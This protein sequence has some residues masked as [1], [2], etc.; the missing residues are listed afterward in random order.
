M[1]SFEVVELNV[2]VYSFA[3]LIHAPDIHFEIV[4]TKQHHN[5]SLIIRSGLKTENARQNNLTGINITVNLFLFNK[6]RRR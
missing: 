3:Q 2:G 5:L 1:W 6:N 4:P